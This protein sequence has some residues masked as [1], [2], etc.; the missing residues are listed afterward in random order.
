MKFEQRDK[1]FMD[2]LAE[3]EDQKFLCRADEK[4]ITGLLAGMKN[5][6]LAESERILVKASDPVGH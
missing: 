2:F 3:I 1:S 5:K 6:T 4:R